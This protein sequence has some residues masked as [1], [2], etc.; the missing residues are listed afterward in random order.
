MNKKGEP[1]NSEIMDNIAQ[2]ASESYESQ[3][4][5]SPE[6]A[7]FVSNI[8]MLQEDVKKLNLPDEQMQLVK[9]L[10]KEHHDLSLDYIEKMYKQAM[11]D[12][13]TLLKELKV[14]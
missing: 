2:Y 9:R 4:L 6:Y 14:H 13:V 3:I 10:L 8:S 5:N 7:Q 11:I 12:C 1:M